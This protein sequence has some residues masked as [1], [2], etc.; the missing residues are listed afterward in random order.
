[1]S[2]RENVDFSLK[3][4]Q[5]CYE[6]DTVTSNMMYRLNPDILYSNIKW[7]HWNKFI[8]ITSKLHLSHIHV[9]S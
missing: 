4:L 1:M 5:C 7:G 9:G 6:Q 3:P 2:R 8:E